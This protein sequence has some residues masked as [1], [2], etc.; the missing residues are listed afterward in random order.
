MNVTGVTD[1]AH[2]L[3]EIITVISTVRTELELRCAALEVFKFVR[4]AKITRL[5]RLVAKLRF[6]RAAPPLK[7]C[8][9][10]K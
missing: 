4:F 3:V 10:P 2:Q 7:Q 6:G 1:M 5:V 8:A 9:V